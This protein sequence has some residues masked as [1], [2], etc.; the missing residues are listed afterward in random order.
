MDTVFVHTLTSFGNCCCIV[1]EIYVFHQIFEPGSRHYI[2]HC[3]VS[4]F[5]L[6]VRSHVGHLDQTHSQVDACELLKFL[7]GCLDWHFIF[8]HTIQV[9]M[10]RSLVHHVVTNE[11]S[12]VHIC[13]N[14]T[15][16]GSIGS[17]TN[18]ASGG[19][20]IFPLVLSTI[21]SKCR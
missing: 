17:G 11:E 21:C 8:L 10:I 2:G 6:P 16:W 7:F 3:C 5:F 1:N 9:G 19:T 15:S 13:R 14:F 18:A 12:V 20:D 4:A